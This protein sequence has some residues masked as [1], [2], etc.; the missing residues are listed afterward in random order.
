MS[1]IWWSITSLRF[2]YVVLRFICRLLFPAYFNLFRSVH[3][4]DEESTLINR[5]FILII[6]VMQNRPCGGIQFRLFP[7]H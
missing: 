7:L 1:D 6:P 4:I 5:E 3:P 2:T